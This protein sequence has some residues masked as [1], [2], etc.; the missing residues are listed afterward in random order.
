MTISMMGRKNAV[1]V[2]FVVLIISTTGLGLLEY[3]PYDQWKLFY[4]LSFVIRFAQ[5][6]GDSLI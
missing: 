3:V 4:A 2:G 6:Y 1:I 5:G